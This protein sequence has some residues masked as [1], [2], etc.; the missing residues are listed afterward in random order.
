MASSKDEAKAVAPTDV[1][2]MDMDVDTFFVTDRLSITTQALSRAVKDRYEAYLAQLEEETKDVRCLVC[3][4][5]R[6]LKVLVACG[7]SICGECFV[8]LKKGSSTAKCPSCKKESSTTV[9]N[10]ALTS[11]IEN[12]YPALFPMLQARDASAKGI[13]AFFAFLG[14]HWLVSPSAGDKGLLQLLESLWRAR[15]MSRFGKHERDPADSDAIEP[16]AK[17][18]ATTE[19]V[20]VPVP[21]DASSS[22]APAPVSEPHPVAPEEKMDVE[23]VL[24]STT[25]VAFETLYPTLLR[26]YLRG[27]ADKI[28]IRNR[29]LQAP[30]F[31]SIILVEWTLLPMPLRAALQ[32]ALSRDRHETRRPCATKWVSTIED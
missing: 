29:L 13:K 23:P 3:F 18:I 31:T 2:S 7:H 4:E 15:V 21:V 10:F 20:T 8:K 19:A 5:T 28:T 22:P 25:A 32:E 9:Q 6:Q 26:K 30:E 24:V 16:A 11:M 27:T 12:K 17:R 14:D 1:V